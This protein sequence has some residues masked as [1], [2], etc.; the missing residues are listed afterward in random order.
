MS[1]KPF[2][3]KIGGALKT[4]ETPIIMGIL[5]ITP[6][7]FYDG[8]RNEKE[9]FLH[10]AEQMLIEGA[11]ILD[12]G[13]QSTRPGATRLSVDEEW[14][15]LEGKIKAI[16]KTFPD[17]IVSVDTFYGTVAE[18]AIAEG[19]QIVNDVS[20]GSI[21]SSIIE[22]AVKHQTPYV[23]M[24]MQGEPQTM[25]LNPNYNDVV[26]DILF[27]FS[28]KIR[29]LQEQNLNDILVDPGF[30][31]GKTLE[32]NFELIKNLKSFDILEKPILVGISRKKL[33][34]KV[35]EK[36]AKDALIGTSA[37]NTIALLNGASILRVHDVS[38]ATDVLAIANFYQK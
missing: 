11:Q 10:R 29:E 35:I 13:G 21:D 4:F 25:Q 17:A 26:Q 12:I 33:I 38:A 6:D 16:R 8:D 22:V 3:L 5:N 20:A 24:H 7:S 27:F 32:H 15:R 36:E 23:L 2:T 9:D 18:R 34:Q 30:G 19:A 31:F 37:L 1:F 28:Q 14:A